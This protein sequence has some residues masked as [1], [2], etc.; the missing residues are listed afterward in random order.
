MPSERHRVFDR[1]P[2]LRDS[3][4][5]RGDRDRMG[6]SRERERGRKTKGWSYRR[7]KKG[8]EEKRRE[9]GA[10]AARVLQIVARRRRRGR[11]TIAIGS[12]SSLFRG[13]WLEDVATPC[14]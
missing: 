11:Q 6:E 3:A 14:F 13:D 4:S 10:S 2:F 12:Y 8:D 5:L 1:G 9:D 7:A